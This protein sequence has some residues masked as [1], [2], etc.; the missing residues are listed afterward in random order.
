MKCEIIIEKKLFCI[1]LN[2]NESAAPEVP[3][4][5]KPLYQKYKAINYTVVVFRS[6]NQDLLKLS[7]ELLRYNRRLFAERE[8]ESDRKKDLAREN[9]SS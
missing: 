8:E 5:L 4:L 7:S 2:R 1:W 3:V 9:Q 6:G